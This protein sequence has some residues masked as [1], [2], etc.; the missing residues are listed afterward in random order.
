[1]NNLVTIEIFGEYLT[2]SAGH[3]TLFSATERERLHGHNYDVSA[4]ITT[5]VQSSG[6]AFNYEIYR[7][8]IVEI[9]EELDVHLLLPGNSP[10][11]KIEEK[12]KFYHAHFNGEDIPF[13]KSDTIILPVRNISLE[14]MARWFLTRLLE[15]K[16]SIRTYA[17]QEFAIHIS[18]G[19]GRSASVNWAAI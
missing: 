7:D 18:S 17:I 15:D 14:E 6:V 8:K 2:F 12:G 5:E 3:F 1:M 19:H 11:L 13:L 4:S 16:K 10:L 9:C